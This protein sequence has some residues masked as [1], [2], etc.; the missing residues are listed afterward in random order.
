MF[1]SVNATASSIVR[2]DTA[3]VC[4]GGEVVNVLDTL[5]GSHDG[6]LWCAEPADKQVRMIER[7]VRRYNRRGRVVIEWVDFIY[8]DGESIHMERVTLH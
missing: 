2:F 7:L 6:V 3:W 8:D 1:K 5:E 4:M